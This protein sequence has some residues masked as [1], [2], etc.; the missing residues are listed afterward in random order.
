MKK[1]LK[2]KEWTINEL[3]D[4]DYYYSEHYEEALKL[5]ALDVKRIIHTAMDEVGYSLLE[6][7]LDYRVN[8]VALGALFGFKEESIPMYL[9]YYDIAKEV[10]LKEPI[11]NFGLAFGDYYYS[12]KDNENAILY[13]S[14]VFKD[15]FDMSKIHYFGQL[16]RFL[17]ISECDVVEFLDRLIKNSVC[18]NPL[19]QP[20]IVDTH[21]LLIVNLKKDDPRYIRYIDR[22][23]FIAESIVNDYRKERGEHT[24]WSDT[25]L[26]RDLC[27]LLALRYIYYIEQKNFKEAIRMYN[28]LTDEIHYSDCTRYYHARD[29]YFFEMLSSMANTYEELEFFKKI[30]FQKYEIL[31]NINSLD[32]IKKGMI[33]TLKSESGKT[34]KFEVLSY[35]G[36]LYSKVCLI[37]I[38]PIFGKVGYLY[39]SVKKQEDKIYL[40]TSF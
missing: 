20:D 4:I 18:E 40:E 9:K 34:N 8:D 16:K 17:K 22:A 1:L 11:F 38:L 6:V 26:E 33:I 7:E 21:L 2:K 13:Y 27:E 19:N 14:S 29:K 15:G 12:L 35:D 25:D 3:L 36:D 31:E 10:G 37:P 39:V 32:D 5:E 24:Y 23:I 30:T 28:R